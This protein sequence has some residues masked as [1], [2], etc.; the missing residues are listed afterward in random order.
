MLK[1]LKKLQNPFERYVFPL[2]LVL[3]PLVPLRQG[4]SVM[5]TTY[6][7]A[8][9]RY[10]QGAGMMWSI[11]TFLANLTGRAFMALPVGK[12]MAG[13]NL[14]CLLL[15]SLTALLCYRVLGR[16]IPGWMIFCGEFL[17]AA[18]CWCPAVILYNYLT[19]LLLTLGTLFLFLAVS[20]VPEKK[21]YYILAGACLGLNVTVRFSNLT[22]AALILALWFWCACAGKSFSAVAKRTL[23][24]ISGYAA[25]FGAGYLL[26]AAMYGPAAYWQM[27]P[28]L[29]SATGNVQS[30]TAAGMLLS[31]LDAYGH[32]LRWFLILVPCMI[33]GAVFFAMP[34]LR[35]KKR[36]KRLLYIAGIMVIVRFYYSRGMFN[37]NYQDY[38]SMFE[39]GMMLVILTLILCIIGMAGA[40]GANPDERFLSA[41]VFVTIL[42]LPLGSN[43][44]TYPVLNCMFIT[45]PYALWMLRRI[46]QETRHTETHFSWHAMTVMILCMALIQGSLFHIFFAFRDGTDGT[47]RSAVIQTLPAAAGM[48][49]TPANAQELEDLWQYLQSE[50]LTGTP[51]IVFGSAPGIHYLMELPPALDSAWPDLDSYPAEQFK[52]QLR[53][54]KKDSLPLI[55]LHEENSPQSASSDEKCGELFDFMRDNAYQQAYTGGAYSVYT[56]AGKAQE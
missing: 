26:C 48:H 18:F 1:K 17:A 44:Y 10:P 21:R 22:Q 24:C 23:F 55:I 46:W 47:S 40:Y 14:L 50:N 35:S 13:M 39:W 3:W 27:I 9:Y 31:T 29:F 28:Q 20:S 11:A 37:L 53:K 8:N 52:E 30:Y 4:V 25:G 45:A 49:T 41:A 19:Y 51:A 38:G 34:L 12:T 15:I 43:N 6:S 42:I 5:D 16:M 54:Q 7:L 32:T 56:A 36:L 2:L 33:M